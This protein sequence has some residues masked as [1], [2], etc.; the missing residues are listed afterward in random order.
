MQEDA[1]LKRLTYLPFL[2]E[3]DATADESL[4]HSQWP[5]ACLIRPRQLFYLRGCHEYRIPY[6]IA[7]H[8]R[9]S[10][11]PVRKLPLHIHRSAVCR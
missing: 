10:K 4:L 9:I 3:N 5:R 1:V 7:R 6:A 8:N 2:V 11:P